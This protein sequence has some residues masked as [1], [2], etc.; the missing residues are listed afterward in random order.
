MADQ[1]IGGGIT[2]R[3][4]QRIAVDCFGISCAA[5]GVDN[6]AHIDRAQ[7]QATGVAFGGIDGVANLDRYVQATDMLSDRVVDRRVSQVDDGFDI[8]AGVDQIHCD[9][10]AVIVT[11]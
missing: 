5:P 3:H 2:H 10:I 7:V 4:A 8:D 6:F 1:L 9:G 11:G